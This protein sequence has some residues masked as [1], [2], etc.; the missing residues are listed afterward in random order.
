[1]LCLLDLRT[2]KLRSP[3]VL[4]V[5]ALS[6]LGLVSLWYRPGSESVLVYWRWSTP[7]GGQALIEFAVVFAFTGAA[8]GLI[9]SLIS[10][11]ASDHGVS[12]G[13]LFVHVF[14]SGSLDWIWSG[15]L[16]G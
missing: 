2:V 9:W 6:V 1:V 16:P 8:I 12:F 11:W 15:R 10:S 3:I 4:G 5:R 7:S 14:Y 13:W